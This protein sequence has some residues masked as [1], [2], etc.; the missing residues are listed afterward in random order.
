MDKIKLH[1]LSFY[2]YHGVFPEENK[3]GQRFY[4]DVEL[5]LPLAKAGKSDDVADSIDYGEV[6][7]IVREI[8]EGEP[9]KLIEAVAETIA[10]SLLNAFDH[11]QACQVEVTKP[12]PPIAGQYEAVSVQVYRE[13]KR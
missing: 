11:L 5:F 12:D 13:R 7:A 6:Y 4:V 2:G 3:L 9:K 10:T 1:R 8:V